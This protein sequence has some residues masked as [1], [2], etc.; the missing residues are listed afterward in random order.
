MTAP[1]ILKSW[2]YNISCEE[3]LQRADHIVNECSVIYDKIGALKEHEVNFD[4]VLG[5]LAEAQ[6]LFA[7]ENAYLKMPMHV[8]THKELR[9][10]S[11]EASL[12]LK[13]FQVEIGMRVDIFEKLQLLE[14]MDTSVLSDE[15]KQFLKR[16]VKSYERNGLCLDFE[17]QKQ[18]KALKNEI[19]DMSVQFVKSLNEDNT[20]LEFTEEE[21]KGLPQ[22]F[23][24]SLEMVMSFVKD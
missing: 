18:V 9:S 13:E 8:S 16:M 2:D 24:N 17:V 10:A 20:V 14:K 4:S 6:R 19:D 12:K 22:D 3:L 11:S 21:L 23:I 5:G 15:L 7:N 1:G